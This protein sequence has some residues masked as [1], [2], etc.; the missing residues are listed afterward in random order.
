[1][2][3]NTFIAGRGFLYLLD[4][5]SK[6]LLV[7]LLCVMVFLPISQWGLWLL[8]GFAFLTAWH[9]M[10]FSQALQPLRAILFVLVLMT[11][12]IPLTYRDGESL[13]VIGRFTVATVESV[14]NYSF[15]VSRFLAITYLC[16]LYLWST[17]MADINLAL[18]WYGLPRNAA[19]VLTLAFRFIPFIAD[20]FKMI[21]DSHALRIGEQSSRRQRLSDAIPTITAALVYALKSIPHFAMSLEHRGLGRS[22]VRTEYRKLKAKGGLFT[23]MLVSVMIPTVFWLLFNTL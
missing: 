14:Q 16:T 1:M 13:L 9:A 12:F 21:K 10:G 23:Q 18:R 5:R 19:L 11:L 15:L 6:L 2:T 3:V 22:G 8:C 7:L 20:S 17:P 4:A